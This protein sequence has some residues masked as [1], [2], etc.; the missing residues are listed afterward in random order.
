MPRAP[1]RCSITCPNPATLKGKCSEHQPLRV[2]WQKT[3]DSPDRS[4][5]KTAEWTRQRLRV[6]YRDN[7]HHGGCQLAILPGCTKV[8]TTVDHKIPVWYGRA[9][10]VEDEALQGLCA[11]CHQQKSSY[12]GVQAKRIKRLQS[13]S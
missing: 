3:S 2:A 9:D 7:T 4:F 1:K 6:L 5:L 13:E 11:Y 10:E 8:A 12:E